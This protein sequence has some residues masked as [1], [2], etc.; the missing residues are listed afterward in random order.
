MIISVCIAIPSASITYAKANSLNVKN[1]TI[2]QYTYQQSISNDTLKVIG[3]L[4]SFMFFCTKDNNIKYVKSI[5]K[6][7][8]IELF[9]KK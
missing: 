7:D 5:D 4:G 1:N 8:H 2:Y 3:K 6:M 9:E